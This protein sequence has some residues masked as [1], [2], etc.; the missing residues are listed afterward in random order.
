M[1]QFVK[2]GKETAE[3]GTYIEIDLMC[4]GIGEGL[5]KTVRV[6][7]VLNAEKKTR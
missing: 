7:R 6:K 4:K 5:G 2:N 1:R 3:E